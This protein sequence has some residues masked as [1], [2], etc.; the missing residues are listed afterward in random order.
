MVRRELLIRGSFGVK[1]QDRNVAVG[2]QLV[3]MPRG[4]TLAEYLKSKEA[5]ITGSWAR[6]ET[7]TDGIRK[8]VRA[9]PRRILFLV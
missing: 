2:E 1:I 4:R 3:Q 7:W 6:G 8:E 9:K 5:S